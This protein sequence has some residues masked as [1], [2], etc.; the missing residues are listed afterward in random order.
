M[1]MSTRRSKKVAASKAYR[2]DLTCEGKRFFRTEQEALEAADIGML[3]NM[4]LSL[5]VYHCATCRYWH[6]TSNSPTPKA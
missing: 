4:R 1:Y 5:G 6:L 2:F 3:N